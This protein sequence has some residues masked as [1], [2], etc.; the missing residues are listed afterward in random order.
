MEKGFVQIYTGEGKGK[1]TAALGL[2]FRAAGRGKKV[3]FVQFLKGIRTGEEISMSENENIIH[4]KLAETVR[5]FLTLSEDEQIELKSK[6]LREW[7]DLKKRIETDPMDILVL[8]EIMAAIHN[9]LVDEMAVVSFLRDRPKYLEVILTGRSASEK[10][11]NEA[12]LV[13]E[14]RN[15]KHYY[16]EGI[17]SRIG[18]E[19]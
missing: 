9:G 6:T 13:T 5:F 11:M 18:I 3:L 16:N 8:D 14:M 1:T 12:D 2:S 10:L 7:G 4:L 17:L 19:Y 15:R